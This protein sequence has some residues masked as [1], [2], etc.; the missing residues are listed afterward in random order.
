MAF[1]RSD[2]SLIARW[3]WTIDRW[4]LTAVSL[5]VFF[6][7]LLS[8]AGSPAV[9]V[10]LDRPEFFFVYRQ[11]FYVSIAI[12]VM[13]LTSLLTPRGVRRLG[14]MLFVGAWVAMVLTL[15]V[16]RELNGA[17]RWLFIGSI[18]FQPS[19]FMKPGFVIIC[20]WMIAEARK[21]VGIPGEI[22]AFLIL[23]LVLSV[24][25]LQPD[26]G[27]ASLVTAVWLLLLFT[28]GVALIW[29]LGLFVTA[30]IGSGIAYMTVPHVTS[31]VDRFLDPA[32]GDTYQAETAMSAVMNGGLLGRGPGEGVLKRVLPDAHTDFIFA[33]AAEEY[34][35]IACAVILG[36]FFFIV[37]RSFFRIVNEQDHFTQLA[38]SGLIALFGMQA[39]I[40]MAVN[41]GLLPAKGMTLPFIS[42]GGSSSVAVGLT[43][44][45]LLALTRRRSG[46]QA[47]N[48]RRT[49]A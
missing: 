20:A 34:G 48:R 19:E 46:S 14:V 47:S 6:G 9:A 11:M 4:S 17:T 32:S 49:A 2:S 21:G 42:Y 29:P 41:L 39:L 24:L 36:V 28:G 38:A 44:G 8:M 10:R 18:S 13:F 37:M 40:N 30:M 16:G 15:L 22:V 25:V 23:G 35:L 33:V 26:Y 7:L 27:Q 5:L 12:A 31:R 43:I 1:A 45:M 3:W